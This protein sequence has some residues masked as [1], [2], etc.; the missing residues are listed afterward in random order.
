MEKGLCW[1]FASLLFLA[2]FAS[3]NNV[4]INKTIVTIATGKVQGFISESR[5][6]KPY[7]EFRGIPYAT[8]PRG[9]LRYQPPQ[10]AK[11]WEGIKDASK[12][13]HK[14]LQFDMLTDLVMGFEDC[15]NINIMTPKVLISYISHIER[16]CLK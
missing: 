14:C 2:I 3:A 9:P 7:V 8:P 12:Y 4:T 13:G 10:A 15:L 16:T 6:G 11:K 1:G 5:D